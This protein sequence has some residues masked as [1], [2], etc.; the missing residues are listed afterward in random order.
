M[1]ESL[2]I[3]LILTIIIELGVSILLG[4]R[5]KDDIYIV[6]LVNICTNPVVVYIANCIML[7]N[8]D[9][10]YNVIVGVME[11]IVVIVEYILYKKYLEHYKKS[12]FML[13]LINN[14]VSFGIGLILF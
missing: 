8:N 1:I 4:I 7:F 12:P 9:I 10:L 13:S 6:I 14:A 11:I 2:I 3:S 5:K